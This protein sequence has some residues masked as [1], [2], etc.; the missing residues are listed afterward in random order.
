MSTF[1]DYRMSEH[2]NKRRKEMHLTEATIGQAL[3]DPDCVYP[4]SKSHPEPD[5]RM[6]YQRGDI[7]VVVNESTHQVITVL[8]H[9]KEGR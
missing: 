1:T 4:S 2:A 8:W 6:V 3:L 9:R 7:C 5:I